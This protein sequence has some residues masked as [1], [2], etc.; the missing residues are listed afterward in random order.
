MPAP[1]AT[2]AVREKIIATAISQ[3]GVSESPAY[4]NNTPYSRWYG[5][6][7]PWCAMFVSWCLHMS[8]LPLRIS[9]SKGFAY[10]P[11]GV[12]WFKANGAWAGPS[13]K[14]KRGWIVFFDFIGRPSHTGL[15]EGNAVDGRIVCLEGNT[16]ASGSRTGGSVMRH[17]RQVA[18]GIIGYGIINYTG[19]N[20]EELDVDEATLRNII[21]SEL[22]QLN[23]PGRPLDIQNQWAKTQFES[24]KGAITTA[25]SSIK[26][27][28]DTIRDGLAKLIRS[29]PGVPPS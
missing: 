21:K 26:T 4:S 28:A 22:N 1:T 2:I 15:V 20:D 9:T 17:H 11:A 7:G 24:V 10:C 23:D 29:I 8:G 12:A 16:N 27:N 5:I 25:V 3:L 6:I 18:S 14:P 13:V 19:T